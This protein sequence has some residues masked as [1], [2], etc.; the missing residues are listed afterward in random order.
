MLCCTATTTELTVIFI[1]SD[2]G[3]ERDL[4]L[5]LFFR[6]F[7]LIFH[8]PVPL[9]PHHP[10]IPPFKQPRSDIS[11]RV[12][13]EVLEI[14]ITVFSRFL[15]FYSIFVQN[16]FTTNRKEEHVKSTC[17]FFRKKCTNII[18]YVHS[19]VRTKKK[20][21]YSA[22]PLLSSHVESQFHF[23]WIYSDLHPIFLSHI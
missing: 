22:S 1:N 12:E 19:N 9:S 2:T 18:I 17:Y 7:L 14:H 11:E 3:N 20:L 8:V 16:T 6:F 4:T 15:L 5:I 23:F 13:N 10:C 21:L